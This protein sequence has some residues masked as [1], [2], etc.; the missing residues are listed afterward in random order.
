MSCSANDKDDNDVDIEKLKDELAG[1]AYGPSNEG[2]STTTTEQNDHDDNDDSRSDSDNIESGNANEAEFE[3]NIPNRDYAE[4]VIK[5]VKKTVKQEDALVRQI[6]YTGLSAYTNDPINLGIIA[7][8]SE[9]KTYPVIETLKP[10]PKEDVWLIGSMSTKLLVRQKGALVDENNEPLKPKIREVKLKLE[11]TKDKKEQQELKEELQELYE[12]ARI[13]ID[14]RCKI[15]VFLEPPQHDL[16]NLLKPILS[17]DSEEIEFPYVDKTDRGMEPKRV[18]VKGWPAC[19]FCSARDESNWPAWP[20]IQSRFLITSP[21]MNST[22]YYESNILISQRKSLPGLIQQRIVISD[23]EI[24]L[25]K[26][27][28]LHLKEEI[29]KFMTSSSTITLSMKKSGNNNNNNPVWIPYGQILAEILPSEKGT[30][31]R[32]TKRIFSL[33]Q[34][35]PLAKA[36]LRH[37][38]IYGSEKLVIASIEDLGEVLHITQNISGLPSYK[39]KFFREIFLPLFRLKTTP[40]EKDGKEE[41]LIALTTKQICDYYK[42]KTAKASSADNIKKK[43]LNELISNDYIGEIESELDKRQ[44]IY[45]PLI[46]LEDSNDKNEDYEEN[47]TKLSTVNIFD[48][49]LQCSRFVLPKY[50][51]NIPENWLIYEI[52]SLAKYRINLDQFEGCLAD[53]LNQHENLQF[54]NKD[55]NRLTIREFI[56]EYEKSQTLIRYFKM[57][58]YSIFFNN[59]YTHLEYIGKISSN[60]SQILSSSDK[61]DKKDIFALQISSRNNFYSQDVL[62]KNISYSATGQQ[63]SIVRQYNNNKADEEK[64]RQQPGSSNKTNNYNELANTHK[65]GPNSDCGWV[66]GLEKKGILIDKRDLSKYPELVDI[67]WQRFE[68]LENKSYDNIVN[69]KELKANLVSS[70]KFFIGDAVQIIG[71]MV[72]AKEIEEVDFDLYKRR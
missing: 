18:I 15:L 28:I 49:F 51:K 17:H 7:P 13:L 65:S 61:F 23:E 10:F 48:N 71:D 46:E 59:Q 11:Y 30:D 12:N 19:I 56:S 4:F 1:E 45:Y 52:L 16:W 21:N 8:T 47:I 43:F 54:L 53:F 58:K 40:N 38:L 39:T 70:N 67:F 64:D 24:Q 14:V 68:E 27:C 2:S 33:L 72:R 42:Q 26:S 31:T 22:K 50:C 66:N 62:I 57:H 69:G 35:I 60:L 29:K 55:G 41:K 63:P 34:I 25:A 36:H 6:F 20:E 9:G 44:Y 5:V 3:S 37:K 32:T